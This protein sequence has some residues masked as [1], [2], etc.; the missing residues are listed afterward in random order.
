[1]SSKTKTVE[2]DLNTYKM[3]YGS[4]DD[5]YDQLTGARKEWVDDNWESMLDHFLEYAE[6]SLEESV[7]SDEEEEDTQEQA[8]E[9][10]SN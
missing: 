10:E 3:L 6:Q 9:I 7:E 5:W 4:I 1:M 8:S 2:R